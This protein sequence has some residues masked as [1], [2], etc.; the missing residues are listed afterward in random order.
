MTST[1]EVSM[2][3][4]FTRYESRGTNQTY[5]ITLSSKKHGGIIRALPFEI[6]ASDESTT[7]F[8]LRPINQYANVPAKLKLA[9]RHTHFGPRTPSRGRLPRSRHIRDAMMVQT[10][11]T[12][13]ASVYL[14]F[15]FT[16][17]V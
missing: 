5:V 14:V 15:V 9:I 4:R 12:P 11:I 7:N 3:P 1:H 13:A 6:Q 8:R 10:I 2:A 16:T 17:P